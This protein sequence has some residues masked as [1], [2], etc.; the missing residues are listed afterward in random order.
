MKLLEESG[1]GTCNLTHVPMDFNVKLSKSPA[2][3]GV[4]VT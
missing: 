2:E 1:M 3:K 4:D